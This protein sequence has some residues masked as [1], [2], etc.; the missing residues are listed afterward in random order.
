ML[1]GQAVVAVFAE[2]LA[3]E[4]VAAAATLA[5][6]TAAG[7]THWEARAVWV[8]GGH[9]PL[10]SHAGGGDGGGAAGVASRTQP[11]RG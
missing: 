6:G 9:L 1:G 5:A 8:G 3:A 10:G 2:L 4:R 11:P 7:H